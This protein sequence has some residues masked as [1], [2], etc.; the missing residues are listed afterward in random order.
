MLI[1]LLLLYL[2]GSVALCVYLVWARTRS[3]RRSERAFDGVFHT[4]EGSVRKLMMT[5]KGFPAGQPPASIADDVGRV[6][7]LAHAIFD[8]EGVERSWLYRPHPQLGG[9][10]PILVALGPDGSARVRDLIATAAH[11]QSVMDALPS[12]PA[13]G[14]AGQPG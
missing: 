2:I 8:D 12:S 9:V 3:G 5:M 7:Y 10:P 4:A 11:G 6:L 1:G 13:A 14:S